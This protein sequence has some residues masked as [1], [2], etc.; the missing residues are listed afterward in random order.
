MAM[1]SELASSRVTGGLFATIRESDAV[2][3]FGETAAEPW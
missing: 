3:A 2:E 1:S